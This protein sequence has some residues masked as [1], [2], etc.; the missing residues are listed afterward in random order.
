MIHIKIQADTRPDLK[1]L[2][3]HV[4]VRVM[5]V[6]LFLFVA[7]VY[8]EMQG[9]ASPGISIIG[10]LDSEWKWNLSWRKSESEVHAYRSIGLGRYE[11]LSLEAWA[12]RQLELAPSPVFGWEAPPEL[13][14]LHPSMLSY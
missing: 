1:A 4:D 2:Y 12:E 3:T 11:H 14:S 7:P 9:S 5:G 13:L 8:W 10:W 6:P